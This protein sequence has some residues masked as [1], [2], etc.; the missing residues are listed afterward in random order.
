MIKH[1]LY[2]SA[3]NEYRQGF[4]VWAPVEKPSAN[5]CLSIC[6]HVFPVTTFFRLWDQKILFILRDRFSSMLFMGKWFYV[7]EIRLILRE[8]AEVGKYA[9]AQRLND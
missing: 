3:F 7:N 5:V 9:G 4:C 8:K 1:E 6:F 2:L